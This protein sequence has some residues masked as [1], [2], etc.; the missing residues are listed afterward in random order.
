MRSHEARVDAPRAQHDHDTSTRAIGRS[1]LTSQLAH[2]DAEAEMFGGAPWGELSAED[3]DAGDAEA[4]EAGP[5]KVAG[6]GAMQ[7][8]DGEHEAGEHGK[9]A[10]HGIGE[11]GK[12]GEHA[13][14]AEPDA[15][16]DAADAGGGESAAGDRGA[17]DPAH[18]AEDGFRD[19]PVELPHRAALEQL[20]GISFAG[21][22]AYTGRHARQATRALGANAYT[23]G[24]R[25]AFASP[26]PSREIVAHE[27]AHVVQHDAS[28]GK[29]GG[30]ETA[31]EHEA[32]QVEAAVA[33]GNR[34]QLAHAAHARGGQR[35]FSAGQRRAPN[36]KANPKFGIGMTFNPP[37]PKRNTAEKKFS[38]TLWSPKNPIEIPIGA[39]PLLNIVVDP[40][41]KVNGTV[42]AGK[43]R[44]VRTN[45]TLDGGIGVGLSYGKS[46]LV[47][48]NAKLNAGVHGG[49]TYARNPSTWTFAGQFA[50]D[51]NFSFG[52]VIGKVV[53]HNFN[54][55]HCD[56]GKLT[57]IKFEKGDLKTEEMGWE[58]GKQPQ[59]FFGLIKN[60]INNAKK[61]LGLPKDAAKKA[62]GALKKAPGAAFKAADAF[63]NFLD[64]AIPDLTPWDGIAPW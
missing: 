38:R 61:I 17:R 20:F 1:T 24:N 45:W 28:S 14:Q 44:T 34:P 57:G 40:S 21:V 29:P 15:D 5:M 19:A 26:N 41:L 46:E 52:V 43:A 31:G 11:P 62:W 49:F 39:V 13:A 53:S 36:L 54:F 51:T 18:I 4:V 33:A 50:I 37:S 63:K 27:L 60:A 58:W 2:D 6:G 55:G 8:P 56:I 7:A 16:D 64:K 9:A 47:A 48:V 10:G 25:I 42:G 23:V 59:R 32:E 12:A 3:A 30:V 35:G 22:Q